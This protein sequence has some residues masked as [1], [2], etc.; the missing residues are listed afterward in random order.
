MSF[1]QSADTATFFYKEHAIWQCVNVAL[2]FQGQVSIEIAKHSLLLMAIVELY[3]QI[4]AIAQVVRVLDCDS[5]D[6]SSN[7]VGHPIRP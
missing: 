3:V 2:S 1:V 6:T 7:L 5:K 4:V